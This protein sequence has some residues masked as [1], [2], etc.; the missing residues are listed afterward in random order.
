VITSRRRS[1]GERGA[2]LPEYALVVSLVLVVCLGAISSLERSGRSQLNDRR[3]ASGGSGE[4]SGVGFAYTGGGG[5]GGG[6]GGGGGGSSTNVDGVSLPATETGK[7]DKTVWV[8]AVT[9]VVSSGGTAVQGALA[10]VTFAYGTT[11]I[12]V[13]CPEA[14]NNQGKITCA[15]GDI[16]GTVAS[17]TMVVDNISGTNIT[18]TA[19]TP[20]PTT[21]FTRPNGM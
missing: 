9:M 10:T 1:R 7:K 19:P 15:L 3:N 11:S 16:P 20:K 13:T 12:Q 17:A 14:S 21:I 2:T 8:A 6:G 18:Y 5:S 4:V